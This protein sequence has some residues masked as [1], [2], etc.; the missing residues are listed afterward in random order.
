M[1]LCWGAHSSLPGNSPKNSVL[2]DDKGISYKGYVVKGEDYLEYFAREGGRTLNR[3][4]NRT[5]LL[6]SLVEFAAE[7]RGIWS[8]PHAKVSPYLN[9]DL[10]WK[11]LPEFYP[12]RTAFAPDTFVV[13]LPGVLQEINGEPF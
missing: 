3:A 4:L 1:L 2:I 6:Q 12:A 5:K 7:K 8:T 11:E 13:Q 10:S 9:T